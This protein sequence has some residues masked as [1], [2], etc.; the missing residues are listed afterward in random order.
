MMKM[1]GKS[2]QRDRIV[3]RANTINMSLIN[4]ENIVDADVG[5]NVAIAM[6]FWLW[7]NHN[8]LTRTL[9]TPKRFPERIWRPRRPRRHHQLIESQWVSLGILCFKFFKKEICSTG[10]AFSR[11]LYG[12][13]PVGVSDT[14]NSTGCSCSMIL[15]VWSEEK[16]H[17]LLFGFKGRSIVTTER[18]CLSP[19]DDH[20]QIVSLG[21]KSSGCIQAELIAR[22]AHLLAASLPLVGHQA[23][24]VGSVLRRSVRV[25]SVAFSLVHQHSITG[26]SLG[27]AGSNTWDISF[28]SS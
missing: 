17:C 14:S 27:S 7:P 16:F 22:D 24:H 28:K 9:Q 11:Q 15:P 12:L 5:A 6:I 18:L 4:V 1:A 21:S 19:L 26:P 23:N 25:E 8:S 20:S 2:R 10:W 13:A 3:K